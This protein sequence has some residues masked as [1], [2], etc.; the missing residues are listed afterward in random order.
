M[1]QETVGTGEA[2]PPGTETATVA[3][4]AEVKWGL[5]F[6][7]FAPALPMEGGTAMGNVA[8]SEGV[9]VE[10]MGMGTD[11]ISGR[12]KPRMTGTRTEPMRWPK[13]ITH[14]DYFDTGYGDGEGDG[15]GGSGDGGGDGY[16][17]GW[18]GGTGWGE[19]DGGGG[20]RR[21]QSRRS[22]G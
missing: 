17:W 18:G 4:N 15:G 3:V 6:L 12:G 5:I 10:G 1:P 2:L 11:D 21:K 8:D 14:E 22:R 13:H 7:R 19:G 20:R 16:G 9:T